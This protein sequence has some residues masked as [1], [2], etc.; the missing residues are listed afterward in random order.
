MDAIRWDL[1]AK[2][3]PIFCKG[4][5]TSLEIAGLA[6]IGST[7]VGYL[8]AVMRMSSIKPLKKF[9]EVYVW[10]FRGI[11][12]MLILFFMYYGCP[13]G[14]RLSAFQAGLVS[15]I[16]NSSSF[17]SEII[18]AGLQAVDK[19]QLEAADSVGMNPIQ[20]NFRVTIPNMIR[21]IIP[22]YINNCVIMLKE[23]AQV[24][25]ITVQDLMMVLQRSYNSTYR[26]LE[27]LGVGA[28]MYLIMT[29]I[30]MVLQRIAENGLKQKKARKK[31]V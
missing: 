30:L 15:M 18:R 12:L 14:L 21:I 6:I 5:L 22:P 29:S 4:A 11:P 16:L 17:K 20:R 13:F 3:M 26:V 2:N 10:F 25:V 27:T 24:S 8:I 19:K 9:A 1:I 31:A 28:I 7:L 23:S